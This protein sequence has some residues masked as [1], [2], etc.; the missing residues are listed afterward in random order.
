MRIVTLVLALS[1]SSL[2]MARAID[3]DANRIT[4]SLTSE[5]PNLD[6]SLSQDTVS[7]LIL[8]LTNEG[9]VRLDRRGDIIPGV[10][11]RW[12]ETPENITFFLRDSAR[13]ANG[14]PVTAHDFV[15]S[16]QRLVD[17]KTGASGSA[18]LV[19]AIKNAE[20]IMD[21][22]LPP[23]ALGVEAIDDYTFR[24]DMGQPAPW[25][26]YLLAG[27]GFYPLNQAF[28]EAQGERYGA[29]AGNILSNGPFVLE[30]WVHSARVELTKN[31]D[32]W[33]SDDIRLDEIDFGYITA[34]NRSLFNLYKNQELAAL[35]LDEQVIKDASSTGHRIMKV[36]QNCISY[37]YIN[38]AD[39]RPTSN[40]KLRRAIR[41]AIDRD[42]LVNNIV[43]MPGLKL[44]DSPFTEA[45]RTGNG[46][47]VAEYPG[48]TISH[49]VV[50]ARRLLAE[51]K[52]EMGVDEIPPII[53]LTN[54]ARQVH[55]E[56][57]QSQL[58]NALG[59]DVRVDKQ[60][61]K[62]YLAKMFDGGFDLTSSGFC[63]GS[64]SDPIA[65]AGMFKS[66]SPF[67]R[68]QFS[69]ENYDALIE[70]TQSTYD[71]KTR[72]EAFDKAQFIL[73]EE[74]AVIPTH[75]MS[76]VYVQHPKLKGLRRYPSVN[77]STGFIA[78]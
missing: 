28:V 10:A 47:F 53:L 74:V 9:L 45:M 36:P 35:R 43:G 31:Q 49:D 65:F 67:N 13:W 75:Q 29:D 1:L 78:Q 69:N 55:A 48:P 41:A 32:Y 63:A 42:S 64:F 23:E 70:V 7:N 11:E 16:F 77:F 51:A 15:Y 73:F 68:S 2:A 62:Q 18:F 66:D 57:V 21:G 58:K 54:E 24:V 44:I 40:L 25:A 50:E 5:P 46:R 71:Q 52:L 60:T 12:I 38:H 76:Y 6:S 34:D 20:K 39:D 61:F 3:V 17:P 72:M 59:L 14:D 30:T 22:D 4:L 56:Y 33:N 26:L 37:M 19:E 8:S 27:S